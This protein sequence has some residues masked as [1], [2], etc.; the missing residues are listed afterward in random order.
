MANNINQR[1]NEKMKKIMF[2]LCA[3]SFMVFS[4]IASADKI[5]VKV[6]GEPVQI[7]QEGTT[8]ILATP[9]T[10]VTAP[11]GAY[12]FTN[13]DRRMVCFTKT[14][15]SLVGLEVLNF[16]L[17]VGNTEKLYCSYNLDQF[18]IQTIS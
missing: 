18:D 8:Y 14:N 13:G 6:P 3:F 4:Q 11:A 2:I 12:Y 15:A 9:S 16:N 10:V 17:S 5:V 1:R 7:K